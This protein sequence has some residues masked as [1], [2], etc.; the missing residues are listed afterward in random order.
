MCI[1]IHLDLPALLVVLSPMPTGY[2][3]NMVHFLFLTRRQHCDGWTI[4]I[5]RFGNIWCADVKQSIMAAY[6]SEQSDSFKCAFFF[7]F[8][9]FEQW[10]SD[11]NNLLSWSVHLNQYTTFFKWQI[12]CLSWAGVRV[13]FPVTHFSYLSYGASFT[14][15]F[16]TCRFSSIWWMCQCLTSISSG[17]WWEPH[18]CKEGCTNN[19]MKAVLMGLW[20]GLAREGL[21]QISG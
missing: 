1:W 5:N 11:A 7:S 19:T 6:C 9:R 18:E 21:W 16:A 10:R 20:Q 14:G 17:A 12:H 4:S 2:C 15:G 3:L 13:R 8:Y